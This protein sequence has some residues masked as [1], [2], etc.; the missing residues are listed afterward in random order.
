MSERPFPTVEVSDPSLERD[1][2]RQVTVFSPALDGRADCTVCCR[3]P[4]RRRAS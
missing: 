4:A 3:R 1:G 2:L